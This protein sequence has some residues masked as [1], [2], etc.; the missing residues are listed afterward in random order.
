VKG[1][2]GMERNSQTILVGST[3]IIFLLVLAG[4]CTLAPYYKTLV[5]AVIFMALCVSI[6]FC[7]F[8][9]AIE[10]Y[11]DE[12]GQRNKTQVLDSSL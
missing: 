4:F 2:G 6:S 1:G 8:L 7:V 9:A 12:E 5:V 10:N 3:S 11:I